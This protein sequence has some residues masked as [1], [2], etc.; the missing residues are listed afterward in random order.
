ML[1]TTLLL[2]AVA[3]LAEIFG[4]VAFWM[5]LRQDRSA[6]WVALGITSLATFAGLLTRSPTEFAGRAYAAYGGVYIAVSVL[7]LWGV[8]GQRPDCWTGWAPSSAWVPLR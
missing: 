7:W 2:Y 8:N 3:A 5:W 1:D 4:C 6:L